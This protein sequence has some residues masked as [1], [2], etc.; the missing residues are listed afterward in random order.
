MRPAKC[1][2]NFQLSNSR[3]EFTKRSGLSV[4]RVPFLLQHDKYRFMLANLDGMID[5]P[6]Y[7]KCVFEAKTSSAYKAEEWETGIPVSYYAQ[8]QHYLAVTGWQGAYIP[9]FD[10]CE[11]KKS[12]QTP[13]L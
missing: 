7:G 2:L 11:L 12:L 5:D 3:E 1:F 10:S 4:T 13:Y 9:V 8:V 6:V